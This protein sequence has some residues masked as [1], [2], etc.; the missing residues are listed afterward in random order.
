VLDM[1]S[2]TGVLAILAARMGAAAVDA[3]DIDE[4]AYRNSVE[5]IATNGVEGT[6]TP[7]LGDATAVRG[8]KY[9]TVVANINRNILLADMAA[10]SA[11]LGEGGLLVV[12]GILEADAE[13]V[14][15]RAAEFGFSPDGARERDGWMALA[16][17]KHD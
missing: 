6:V 11:A 4:W 5:N 2:G 17:V 3:V 13:A 1:G 12:S 7:I 14:T 9:D 10:Y 15:R 16:F 8:K